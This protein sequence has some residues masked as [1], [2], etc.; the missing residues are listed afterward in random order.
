LLLEL[1]LLPELVLLASSA[2][3]A[4]LGAW[5]LLRFSGIFWFSCCCIIKQ[6]TAPTATASPSSA[7]NVIIPLL[8]LAI[9]ELLYQ[10]QPQQ[11][12]GLSLHNLRLLLT[13]LQFQLP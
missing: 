5:N 7:F 8:Q 6:T 11:L 3:G 1:L 10:N 12:L 13:K 9:L 2:T 4:L